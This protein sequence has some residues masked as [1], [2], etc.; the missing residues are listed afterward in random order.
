MKII[1]YYFPGTKPL[2]KRLKKNVVPHIFEWTPKP[3]PSAVSRSIRATRKLDL[4]TTADQ[5][6]QMQ[7]N[8]VAAEETVTCESFPTGWYSAK[9]FTKLQPQSLVHEISSCQ[10]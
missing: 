3:T 4:A 9:H 8:E 10:S 7:L 1:F 5:Q 2:C 6:R